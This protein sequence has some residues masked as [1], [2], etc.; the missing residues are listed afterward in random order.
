MAADARLPR[1]AS[2]RLRNAAARVPKPEG[3]VARVL[4]VGGTPA[5]AEPRALPRTFPQAYAATSDIAGDSVNW[6]K[7]RCA[8]KSTP[9]SVRRQRERAIDTKWR[10]VNA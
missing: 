1:P 2:G 5:V 9:V 7:K 4:R 3:P 6:R 8:Q 10:A